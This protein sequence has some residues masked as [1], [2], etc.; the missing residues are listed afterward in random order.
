METSSSRQTENNER[1]SKRRQ[2][3]VSTGPSTT[4]SVLQPHDEADVGPNPH[5]ATIVDTRY[6]LRRKQASVQSFAGEARVPSSDQRLYG[7]HRICERCRTI[8]FSQADPRRPGE[9]YITVD[10]TEYKSRLNNCQTC[11][12]FFELLKRFRKISRPTIAYLMPFRTAALYWNRQSEGI[13]ELTI[14]EET[15][16]FLLYDSI[17]AVDTTL[18]LLALYVNFLTPS[19]FNGSSY[20]PFRYSNL[21]KKANFDRIR[22]F[23]DFCQAH[24][25]QCKRQVI[26]DSNKPIRVIDCYDKCVVWLE[27]W[28][29]GSCKEYATLSY[30]WGPTKTPS[31]RPG[32]FGISNGVALP[33]DLPPLINDSIM[34]TMYLGYR[35]LWVDAYCIDQESI[36]DKR[37]QIEQMDAIY[38]NSVATLITPRAKDPSARVPGVK[39]RTSGSGKDGLVKIGGDTYA[40]GHMEKMNMKPWAGRGWT[41]QEAVL[42]GRRVLF[43]EENVSVQCHR[44]VFSERFDVLNEHLSQTQPRPPDPEWRVPGLQVTQDAE[45]QVWTHIFEYS[46]RNLTVADDALRAIFGILRA[47]KDVHPELH[48]ISGLPITWRPDRSASLVDTFAGALNWWHISGTQRNSK[49]PSW[50]WLGWKLGATVFNYHNEAARKMHEHWRFP[51]DI[52]IDMFPLSENQTHNLNSRRT[53]LTIYFQEHGNEAITMST[54]PL[55]E[56][57]APTITLELTISESGNTTMI[58]IDDY[59]IQDRWGQMDL[60]LDLPF[61]TSMK[62]T[63]QTK[64]GVLLLYR[65]DDDNASIAEDVDTAPRKREWLRILIV[66]KVDSLEGKDVFE[67]IGIL[68]LGYEHATHIW[69]N[70]LA[71]PSSILLR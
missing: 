32:P 10:L 31:F 14:A 4:S 71:K 34:A 39:N 68:G 57:T 64:T 50:S 45:A 25:K 36:D 53:H 8:D 22:G 12:V 51:F 37:G 70:S 66:D 67:R 9:T 59:R 24:H 42:S 48:Y 54:I 19:V 6:K 69:S 60:L 33:V 7:I 55:I 65:Y 16:S 62:E 63:K 21:G 20:R 18:R 49:F 35:Y 41:Y 27:G 40:W 11:H 43:G 56:I 26:R 61:P 44:M 23:L 38:S 47:L 2:I 46:S 5:V 28:E 52:L 15:L 58:Q 29:R 3:E 17:V 30:V 1:T 13:S